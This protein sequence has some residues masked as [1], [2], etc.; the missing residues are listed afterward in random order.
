M[1]GAAQ[2]VSEVRQI[3]Y[4]ERQMFDRAVWCLLCTQKH[5][6]REI[7]DVLNFNYIVSN[8]YWY[9]SSLLTNVALR[10]TPVT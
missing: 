5:D 10:L 7:I 6:S 2:F 3:Y 4:K 8:Y 9:R 1:S